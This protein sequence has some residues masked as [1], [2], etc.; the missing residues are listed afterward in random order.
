MRW[1]SLCS[2]R[3]GK[4]CLTLVEAQYAGLP[5][6]VS[7]NVTREVVLSEQYVLIKGFNINCWSAALER[8]F[9]A[10]K[11]LCSINSSQYDINKVY[12]RLSE[13]YKESFNG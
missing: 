3:C 2:L 12:S 7:E 8:S 4:D 10:E 13:M 5:C 11:K 6:I 1:T 9:D